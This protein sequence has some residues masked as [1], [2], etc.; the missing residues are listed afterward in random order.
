VRRALRTLKI[1]GLG[2]VALA[3]V[4]PASGLASQAIRP[5]RHPHRAGRANPIIEWNRFLLGIQATPGD[6]PATVHATYDLAI[7]H[8][9]IYDAVASIDRSARPYLLRVHAPR[10]ASLRAAVD[11]AAHATLV[12]LYPT[13]HAAIDQQYAELLAQV[14]GGSGKAQGIR[15]GREVA[16]RILARRADDGS[17][18]PPIPFEP[19]TAPGDY[20]LTPPAMAAPVF[21]QWAHVRPF[22]LR[23]ASQFRPPPP[24]ALTSP[25]Y[26]A[27]IDEVEALGAAQGSTRTADQ[28]QIGQF[29]NPPIWATWNRI[30]ETAALGHDGSVAQDARAFAALNLTFADSVIAFYDAK[31]AYRF[32]RPVTAIRNADSDGNPET[33]ADPGWTPL[34]P[35][36]PDP[37]YP[38]AHGT[39]SAAGA[40]MLSS[41]YGND[42][43]F[44][45]TSPALPGVERSFVSF[46]EAAEEASV[47]RIYNGNHTRLDQVAGEDVGRDVAGFV[48]ANALRLRAER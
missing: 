8:A 7:M 46:S 36:A 42:F 25:K 43:D 6:Q 1:A 22:V 29:W 11:A 28:T 23:R 38:G 24:P 48:L 40:A 14:P 31:Y 20:Q 26:A 15:V 5:A 12:Q 4:T 35:T 32:W 33:V 16:A 19:S 39:I 17:S 37:S 34:S 44:T 3:A 10:R 45:V 13:L 9:A 30:A 41:L 47:S 18:A 27:A 21:T 2:C